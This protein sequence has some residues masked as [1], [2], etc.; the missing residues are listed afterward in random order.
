MNDLSS[1]AAMTAAGKGIGHLPPV[2]SPHLMREGRLV[3]V[4]PDWRFPIF[5]L[6]VV[7]TSRRYVTRLVRLF[8]EYAIHMAPQLFPELPA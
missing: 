7:R 4:I 8:E 3:E 6:S 5:D 1:V 2:V